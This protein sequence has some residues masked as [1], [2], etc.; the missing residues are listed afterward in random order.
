[1]VGEVHDDNCSALQGSGHAGL[2]GTVAGVLDFAAWLL[3]RQRR[4][5]E[6]GCV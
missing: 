3:G 1:M 2:F 4:A 5:S 6:R